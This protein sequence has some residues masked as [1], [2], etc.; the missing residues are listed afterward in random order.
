[1]QAIRNLGL[2]GLF[3]LLI[4]AA[5][6]LLGLAFA[7]RPS[8]RRLALM[9]PLSL[10]G[11]FAATANVFLG[12]TN[13]LVGAARNGISLVDQRV[14]P[15]LAEVAVLGFLSFAFLTVALAGR[16]RRHE[17]VDVTGN[18]CEDVDDPA[19]PRRSDV[20]RW[21]AR[22]LVIVGLHSPIRDRQSPTNQQSKITHQIDR[23]T[24]KSRT[25]RRTA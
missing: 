9:R 16:G 4:T 8:E 19:S 6:M 1:M 11:M 20:V 17:K 14:V 18:H 3:G 2:A 24:V 23:R 10:A 7:A 15:G 21:L 25:S 22:D 12:V 13:S 5:P